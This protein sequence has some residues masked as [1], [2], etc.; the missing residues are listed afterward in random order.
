MQFIFPHTT[1]SD[2]RDIHIDMAVDAAGTGRTGNNTGAS[3]IVCEVTNASSARLSYLNART[4]RQATVRGIFRFYTEHAAERHFE[5]HPALELDV[6]NG[7]TFVADT[8][9]HG[10]IATVPDGA[11]HT[12]STLVNLLNGSQTVTTTMTSDNVHAN[13]TFPSPSVN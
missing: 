6:W 9:Y 8:D 1:I 5:L 11:T 2:D 10:N 12:S 3:P 13:I 4:G 7:S